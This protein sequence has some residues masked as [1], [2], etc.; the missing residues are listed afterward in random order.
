MT[1]STLSNR[2]TY[3]GNGSTTTFPFAFKVAAAADL[4]VI[5]TDATG[6]DYT[7]ASGQYKAAVALAASD[8]A[9]CI[10]VGRSPLLRWAP[11]R[12]WA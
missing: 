5:W 12:P 2:I 4:T 9:K 11:P 10:A 3:A 8:L 1:V 6:T 7:L